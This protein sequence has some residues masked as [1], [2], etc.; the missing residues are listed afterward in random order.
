MGLGPILGMGSDVQ[1][2]GFR[3]L[4][5]GFRASGCGYRVWSE[6]FRL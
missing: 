2:F 4:D 3:L 1:G 6:R 5:L